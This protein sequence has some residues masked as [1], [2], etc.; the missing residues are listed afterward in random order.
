VIYS[1]LGVV[2]VAAA[3]LVG[4]YFWGLSEGQQALN[5]RNESEL[6][7]V[8]KALTLIQDNKTQNAKELLESRERTLRAGR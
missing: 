7:I 3:L 2:V 5:W 4:G 8:R 1:I 6:E